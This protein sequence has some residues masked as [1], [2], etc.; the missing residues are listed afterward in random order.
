MGTQVFTIS[1]II[2]LL[3]AAFW[4]TLWQRAR[5]KRL[6]EERAAVSRWDDLVSRHIV[7]LANCNK[8]EDRAITLATTLYDTPH[9]RLKG[10]SIY[11]LKIKLDIIVEVISAIRVFTIL[12]GNDVIQ[13]REHEE[14]FFPEK[15]YVAHSAHLAW[16]EDCAQMTYDRMNA[17]LIIL[18]ETTHA[19][20]YNDYYVQDG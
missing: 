8:L 10:W 5:I 1:V 14:T 12:F 13:V 15:A 20:V 11:R 18:E 7:L 19:E 16:L 17:F 6:R 2:N 9:R 4:A 3:Q